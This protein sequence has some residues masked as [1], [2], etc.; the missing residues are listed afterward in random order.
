MNLIFF[1][2]KS[3]YR[4]NAVMNARKNSIDKFS[5]LRDDGVKVSHCEEKCLQSP[6]QLVMLSKESLRF[7][8][9]LQPNNLDLTQLHAERHTLRLHSSL[10]GS[11]HNE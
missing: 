10:Q 6:L 11:K 5:L 7:G 4:I 1:H 3:F 9:F 2:L 8:F